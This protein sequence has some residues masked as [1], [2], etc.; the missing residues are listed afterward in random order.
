LIL[1]SKELDPL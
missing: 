1:Y